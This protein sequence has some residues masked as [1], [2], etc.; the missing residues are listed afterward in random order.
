M[1]IYIILLIVFSGV[2]NINTIQACTAFLLKHND[3]YVVGL[4][5]DF[6]SN[7]GLIMINPR[8]IQKMA[9]PFPEEVPAYWVAKYGSVTFNFLGREE[10]M[11]GIN[12]KGLIIAALFLPETKLSVPD[13]RPTVDDM[14][15]IQYMLDNCANVEEV[16]TKLENIRISNQSQTRIHYFLSDAKGNFATIEFIEGQCIYH[17]NDN[18]TNFF[19]SNVSF[20]KSCN[21]LKGFDGWGGNKPLTSAFEKQS[22]EDIVVMGAELLK[23]YNG[24]ENIETYVF[25]ILKKVE[26]PRTTPN[27]GSQ[28]SVIFDCKNTTI[29]FKTLNNEEIRSIDLKELNFNC[30]QDI[31]ALSIVNSKAQDI[32]SQFNIFTA[33]E[34]LKLLNVRLVKSQMQPL[35]CKACWKTN[36]FCYHYYRTNLDK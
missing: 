24:D 7:Q 28:W 20:D 13:N 6:H 5:F 31:K 2:I 22:A 4:N 35:G 3:S 18:S 33:D 25:E 14:Q 10:P 8:N 12:E 21:Y 26:A 1:K 34:N 15:W 32:Y 17:L 9:I 11:E 19:I 30:N 23:N 36:L 29:K 16:I 27:Y